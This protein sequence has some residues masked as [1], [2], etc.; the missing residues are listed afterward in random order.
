M[1]EYYEDRDR[2]KSK[3]K[4]KNR[5]KNK[6]RNRNKNTNTTNQHSPFRL[7]AACLPTPQ[8][9]EGEGR[10]RRLHR[11]LQPAREGV[12]GLDPAVRRLAWRY[13]HVHTHADTHMYNISSRCRP[14]VIPR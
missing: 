8:L 1:R 12:H 9:P 2:N 13:S 4:S 7:L 14:A 11:Q 5:N 3:S 10:R 6:N